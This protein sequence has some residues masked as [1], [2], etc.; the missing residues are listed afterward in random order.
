MISATILDFG[1]GNLFSVQ[2]ALEKS[3]FEK[4]I[5]ASDE[6]QIKN[7]DRL[8]LPGVGA[9]S[10]GMKGIHDINCIDPIKDFAKSGKPILGICLGMQMLGTQSHEFGINNGLNLIPGQIIKIPSEDSDGIKRR[11]PFVG[12]TEL[13]INESYG[14]NTSI[15]DKSTPNSSVYLVHSYQFVTEEEKDALAFYEY[16]GINITA[17]IQHENI[18]GLQF[19]PEK[20]SEVGLKILNHFSNL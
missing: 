3:G 19:H 1:V 13:K 12:W 7:A 2:K 16:N 10:N 11:V 6:S 5:I 20:S 17:A 9:F 4:V 8:I 15:L 14:G 18:I